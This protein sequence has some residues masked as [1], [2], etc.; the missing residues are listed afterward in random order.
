M[1]QYF[2]TYNFFS[3]V[4]YQILATFGKE[5]YFALLPPIFPLKYALIFYL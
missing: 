1:T 5:Q 2:N 4:I 3:G